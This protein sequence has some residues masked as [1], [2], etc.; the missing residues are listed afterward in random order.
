MSMHLLKAIKP[1]ILKATD[2]G[3]PSPD[4]ANLPESHKFNLKPQ[5]LSLL[6]S[7]MQR[8]A[9]HPS[10]W[11]VQLKEPINGFYEWFAFA[12]HVEQRNPPNNWIATTESTKIKRKPTSADKLKDSDKFDMPFQAQPLLANWV[13]DGG[14]HYE[15]E[16]LTPYN[17]ISNWFAFK[18]H[19][20]V[21]GK[22]LLVSAN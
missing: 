5:D 20:E 4:A 13:K 12:D 14:T 16:L 2:I 1:T 19:V 11:K 15:F 8:D 18:D 17:G 10:Y 3:W 21:G 22:S 6:V 7:S 9:L